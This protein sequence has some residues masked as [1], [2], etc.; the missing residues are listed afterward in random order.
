MST[1]AE[2]GSGIHFGTK[3]TSV[4]VNTQLMNSKK[5][6]VTTSFT[7]ELHTSIFVTR[8]PS[9]QACNMA[10]S[11]ITSA[12]ISKTVQA[13]SMKFSGLSTLLSL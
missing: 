11:D 8:N 6:V 12:N 3:T 5:E 1:A 13:R 4:L 10:L 7:Q 2:S 9:I